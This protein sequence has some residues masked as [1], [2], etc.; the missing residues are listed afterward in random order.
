[1]ETPQDSRAAAP[2]YHAVMSFHARFP[3]IA[4]LL[5]FAL[6]AAASVQAAEP[7]TAP[8]D[9]RE[10]ER[11][12]MVAEQIEAR[13]VADPRV[14]AALRTVPRHLFVPAERAADAYADRA[15]AIGYDATIS[16]P[17]VVAVMTEQAAV[18]PGARVLEVGTGS[19]YQAALLAELGCDVYTIEIV[20]P[21]ARR[22]E[23]TLRSAGFGRVHVRAG[24]GYRGWPEAAPFDAIVVTAGA[25]RVPQ[26]L[27]DQ[28]A[29]GGR[30]V[31][32]VDVE[33]GAQE[34]Q[35]H[36]RSETGISVR[37]VLGVI[38]VPMTGEVQK[39]AKP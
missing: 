26:P 20:E 13:G 33:G 35:V 16:Q 17:Y 3:R 28:L 15:V 14:L 9:R 25:P 22:A 8:A 10:A 27:L 34:L 11:L 7:A 36:E 38:F 5:A 6:C 21:L 18:R 24:D 37:R 23:A 2:A 39:P 30:L 4:G 12:R 32:P 1:M 31:I 19:G 29:V